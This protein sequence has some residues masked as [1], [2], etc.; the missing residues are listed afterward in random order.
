M[1]KNHP[2]TP[3]APATSS[4]PGISSAMFANDGN[5]FE[6]FQA[7]QQQQEQKEKNR[8]LVSMK[9]ATVKKAAPPKPVAPRLD[10]FE[11]PE[12]EENINGNFFLFEF[13]QTT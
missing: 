3:Q 8:P 12:L 11:K 9:L 10:V 4:N 7:M 2:A 6:R 5:F 13:F 1:A